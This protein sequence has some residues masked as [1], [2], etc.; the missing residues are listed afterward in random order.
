MDKL[1]LTGLNLGRVFNS[2]SGCVCAMQ[3][4]CFETKLPYLMSKT[5][6]K[7]LLGYLPLDIAL[8]ACTIKIRIVNFASTV[9]RVMIVSDTTTWNITYYCN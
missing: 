6:P 5:R 8:P 1:Q 4:L 7:Q 3:L 9:I 2:R